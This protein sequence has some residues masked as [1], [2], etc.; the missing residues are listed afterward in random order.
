MNPMRKPP[1]RT[2]AFT[3]RTTLSLLVAAATSSP[4][5]G[6]AVAPSSRAPAAPPPRPSSEERHQ[7]IARMA[8]GYAERAGFATDPF[9]NWLM[10]EREVD[11]MLTRRA[12]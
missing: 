12:G 10:A 3:A 6:S 1:V 5:P 4:K 11:R 9:S 2:K 7:M 8:Y